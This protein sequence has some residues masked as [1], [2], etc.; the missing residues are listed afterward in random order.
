VLSIHDASERIQAVIGRLP[1]EPVPLEDADGRILATPIVAARALPG[2]ANSAMD[3]FAVRAADLPGTLPVVGAIAAGARIPPELQPGTAVRIMTGA[4]VPPGADTIVMFEDATTD[5]AR[6]T[7]P[8]ARRGDHVRAIGEDV[9]IGDAAVAA[10][11]ALRA[12]EL[13]VAAALGHATVTVARRPRVA[14]LSTGDEL[15]TVDAALAPG[16]LVDSSSYGLAAAVRAAG[17]EPRRL[18]IVADDRAATIAAIAAALTADV[19]ITTGGVS[20]G[21]H[22]HVRDALAAAGVTLDFWKVA[23]KPG[24]PFAFGRTATAAV[25]ALPGNPVSS[26]TAF[27]LFVRPALL[28]MQGA[29]RTMRPRAPVVLLDGFR[30]PAGRAHVLRAAIARD[31]A[32]LIATPHAKQGSA[33]Q[34]S[35]VG[36]D[37]LVE[38]AADVTEV[39]PGATA[40]AWLLGA[41]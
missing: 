21:D 17:G 8:A 7:L 29:T 19:V 16:Q 11:V 23:M 20:A 41:C 26:F 33:M 13:T 28:A 24:K 22:D 38:I 18:G 4:P 10:G 5:G 30:K 35:L 40:P 9:A 3:G 34:S 27:E 12:G 15:V 25:F 32:R 37:A 14:I 2:F 1:G 39:A 6:V 31:G 36:C